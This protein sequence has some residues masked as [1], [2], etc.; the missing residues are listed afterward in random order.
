MNLD[1]PKKQQEFLLLSY[2]SFPQGK[3]VK[4]LERAVEEEHEE[5]H[6]MM[7]YM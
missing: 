7:T 6:R 1:T 3:N 4:E 5:E 2:L